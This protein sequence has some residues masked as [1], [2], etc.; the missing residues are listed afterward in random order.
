MESNCIKCGKRIEID[1]HEFG[2]FW[3]AVQW[4]VCWDC[5]QEMPERWKEGEDKDERNDA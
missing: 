1:G 2:S 4:P 3:V 5:V